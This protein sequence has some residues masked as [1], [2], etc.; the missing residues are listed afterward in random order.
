MDGNAG[1]AKL[2]SYSTIQSL[3]NN[4]SLLAQMSGVA[5]V[6]SVFVRPIGENL[7]VFVDDA[8]DKRESMKSDSAGIVIAATMVSLVLTSI[9]LYGMYRRHQDVRDKNLPSV[10][11]T[12]AY[13]YNKRRRFFETLAD[14]EDFEPGWMTTS[15]GPTYEPCP[16][17][18]ITWS[19]SDLTSDSHSIRSTLQLDR[20]VEE[21]HSDDESREG[22]EPPS[23]IYRQFDPSELD[24]VAQWNVSSSSVSASN[25]DSSKSNDTKYSFEYD[26]AIT[27]FH[28]N[29]IE[30]TDVFPLRG[31]QFLPDVSLD[32]RSDASLP[33]RTQSDPPAGNSSPDCSSTCNSKDFDTP[34]VQTDGVEVSQSTDAV[35]SE[36]NTTPHLVILASDL[37]LLLWWTKL[38]IHLQRGRV[39]PRLKSG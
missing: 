35:E 24:F 12:L 10:K 21:S 33:L 11:Q 30:D 14:D 5:L 8:R 15:D 9:F 3:L 36:K 27:C 29:R 38:L 23:H 1:A 39:E 13:L 2:R 16:P 34:T 28:S 6:D 18:S 32:E 4:T 22:F 7:V 20:I 19:V 17:P 37:S 31:C 26:A 25:G